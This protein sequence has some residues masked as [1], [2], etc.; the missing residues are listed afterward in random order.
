[1]MVV[2]NDEVVKGDSRYH[3]PPPTPEQI[4]GAF[5]TSPCG[6]ENCEQAFSG[7]ASRQVPKKSGCEF[8]A[9]LNRFGAPLNRSE[10]KYRYASG[11]FGGHRREANHALGTRFGGRLS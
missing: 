10:P 8:S 1:M 7:S 11:R 2:A 3:S 9:V 4:N 6:V 5:D